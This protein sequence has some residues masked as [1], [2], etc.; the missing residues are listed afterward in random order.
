MF[1]AEHTARLFVV[2][3]AAR[4]SRRNGAAPM[5]GCHGTP[6]SVMC[7][8][9]CFLTRV[10]LGPVV[11]A[12][13]D[14]RS[15]VVSRASCVDSVVLIRVSRFVFSAKGRQCHRHGDMFS[16]Q[17]SDLVVSLCDHSCRGLKSLYFGETW[18]LLCQLM[19]VRSRA[20]VIP[21]GGV[22]RGLRGMMSTRPCSWK[23]S[24]AICTLVSFWLHSIAP[25][26]A[27][28]PEKDSAVLWPRV[29]CSQVQNTQDS[30]M[31]RKTTI[32]SYSDGSPPLYMLV[33]QH[34]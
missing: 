34:V 31:V 21:C 3:Y 29:S 18:M 33:D 24:W 13:D 30:G 4:R 32:H 15:V 6:P 10:R 26:D 17:R 12:P 25:I 19:P 16:F 2:L 5:H 8:Y 22:P 28:H 14:V 7:V 20:V 23:T 1:P 27:C 11:V 9:V